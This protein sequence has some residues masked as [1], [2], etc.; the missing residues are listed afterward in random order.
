[1]STNNSQ[2]QQLTADDPTPSIS[3]TAGG[4]ISSSAYA[5]GPSS[6]AG[7]NSSS[8]SATAASASGG[9]ETV[10]P[11]TQ[12]AGSNDDTVDKP[13]VATNDVVNKKQTDGGA[14]SAASGYVSGS[15]SAAVK[16]S[17]NETTSAHLPAAPASATTAT[18]FQPMDVDSPAATNTETK[19]KAAK[20]KQ[21]KVVKEKGGA[22]KQPRKKVGGDGDGALGDTA[23]DKKKVVKKKKVRC[24]CCSVLHCPLSSTSIDSLIFVLYGNNL[25]PQDK[26]TG[27]NTTRRQPSAASRESGKRKKESA[28][29]P[30]SS[31]PTSSNGTKPGYSAQ[32]AAVNDMMRRAL[33]EDQYSALGS[34]VDTDSSED[35]DHAVCTL[36]V[37]GIG[38]SSR[39]KGPGGGSTIRMDR[40]YIV[41]AMKK[42]I[43]TEGMKS[44][45]NF[46]GDK[47]LEDA[48]EYCDR[49]SGAAAKRSRSLS[50]HTEVVV[51]EGEE[52]DRMGRRIG[53]RKKK[54]K[55]G[56]HQ[57]AHLGEVAMSEAGDDDFDEA[58]QGGTSGSDD[59]AD[60]RFGE[61]EESSIF[62]QTAGSSNAT[63]V[64]CDRCK[65][66]NVVVVNVVV[67]AVVCRLQFVLTI[68][69]LTT[70]H[71]FLTVETPSWNS[72]CS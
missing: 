32:Q 48:E 5:G 21:P 28:L 31:N 11:Q 38:L 8:S 68:P 49:T 52:L 23:G 4:M 47:F 6:S 30:D 54:G 41:A 50:P 22:V 67:I 27:P 57:S 9:M 72:R 43:H 10:P 20:A 36:R 56:K 16:A 25:L 1:M 46:D 58:E 17:S 34:V 53:K 71:L 39:P 42:H 33:E 37:G 62:G 7:A 60:P 26:T 59:N 2:K 13:G 63:W 19:I 18:D 14:T 40:N 24:C 29:H 15:S 55:R 44:V 3:T 65:K 64:E 66:V 35:E 61:E 51:E 12:Q 70:L 69:R 45:N